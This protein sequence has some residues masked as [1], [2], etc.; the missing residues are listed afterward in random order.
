MKDN[1]EGN[2]LVLHIDFSQ[3]H[4]SGTYIDDSGKKSRPCTFE[5]HKHKSVYIQVRHIQ[6]SKPKVSLALQISNIGTGKIY[7]YFLQGCLNL[8]FLL[9]LVFFEASHGEGSA[10]GIGTARKQQ[11]DGAVNLRAVDIICARK[12]I[13]AIRESG[14]YVELFEIKADGFE[15]TEHEIQIKLKGVPETMKNHH[16]SSI[17]RIILFYQHLSVRK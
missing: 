1:L 8:N 15:K 5:P 6:S 4:Q 14:T 17:F 2:E 16:L 12:M 11:A 3:N 9:D 13:D 10:D 7:I